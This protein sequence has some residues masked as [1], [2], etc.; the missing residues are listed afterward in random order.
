MLNELF[1]SNVCIWCK[2]LI[3]SIKKKKTK[4]SK[5]QD[6]RIC[7]T[8]IKRRLLKKLRKSKTGVNQKLVR[9]NNK[10]YNLK[11][12]LNITKIKMTNI[13]DDQLERLLDS[14]GITKGQSELVKEIFSAA[15]FKNPKNRRYNENWVM[16]CLLFQIR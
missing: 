5:G 13:A 11:S 9:A 14:S 12:Q 1:Y 15:K 16:L 4:I 7:L 2:R 3:Y 6:P 8:P 10:I